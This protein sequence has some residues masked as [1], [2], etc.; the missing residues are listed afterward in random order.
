MLQAGKRSWSRAKSGDPGGHALQL[1]NAVQRAYLSKLFFGE[2]LWEAVWGVTDN[3]GKFP[4][5]DKA[6]PPRSQP[7]DAAMRMVW[8]TCTADGAFSI[9]GVRNRDAA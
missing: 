7:A 9:D 1:V 2:C 8:L 4:E 5:G 3:P 6:Q